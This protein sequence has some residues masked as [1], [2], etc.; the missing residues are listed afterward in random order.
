MFK[1]LKLFKERI[2][3]A[4]LASKIA[5]EATQELV[6]LKE[7]VTLETFELSP[8]EQTS[9]NKKELLSFQRAKVGVEDVPKFVSRLMIKKSLQKEIEYR[10]KY[11]EWRM[12]YSHAYFEALS[13]IERSCAE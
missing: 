13:R 8:E 9:L 3:K 10:K 2:Q 11:K 6:P 5:L 4:E 1:L 12:A 7:K